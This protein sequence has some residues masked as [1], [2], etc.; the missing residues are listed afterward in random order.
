MEDIIL[1]MK[2]AIFTLYLINIIL[3]KHPPIF[4]NTLHKYFKI[5]CN[6][7]KVFKFYKKK[8]FNLFALL[9]SYLSCE[10]ITYSTSI[11]LNDFCLLNSK[12][13]SVLRSTVTNRDVFS[14]RENF[15]QTS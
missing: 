12:F 7:A 14:L 13:L 11:S 9:A 6:R 8:E 3:N 4:N 15:S 2:N 5:K 1:I 10:F